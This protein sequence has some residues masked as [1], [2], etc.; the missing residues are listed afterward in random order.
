MPKK[1]CKYH[2]YGYLGSYGN[3]DF[4]KIVKANNKNSAKKKVKDFVAKKYK[5]P[6][7]VEGVY[8]NC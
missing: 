8:K 3:P 5:E 1:E 7:F 2:V 6:F 4:M